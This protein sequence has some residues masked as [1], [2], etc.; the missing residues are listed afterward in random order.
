[1]A[2]L[3]TCLQ[4]ENCPCVLPMHS[5][6]LRRRSPLHAA[7]PL[8]LAGAERGAG[9]SGGN[10]AL[11]IT[12][13]LVQAHDGSSPHERQWIS[14]IVVLVDQSDRAGGPPEIAGTW[15]IPAALPNQFWS[16]TWRSGDTTFFVH[17]PPQRTQALLTAALS[18]VPTLRAFLK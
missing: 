1:M 10:L 11:G 8:R 14:A 9:T 4:T 7:W 15:Y 3:I 6:L 18:T 17:P 12:Y 16:K 2:S 13:A 5:S